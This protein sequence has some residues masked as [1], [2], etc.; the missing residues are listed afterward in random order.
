MHE[1]LIV[2]TD[3]V[4]T[5]IILGEHDT[6][7]VLGVTTERSGLGLDAGISEEV[8]E[9]VIVTGSE[10]LTVA[11]ASNGVDVSTISAA[12]VDSLGL[13]LELAC[14]GSPDG[15]DSVGTA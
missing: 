9:T 5:G 11:G 3:R 13:P 14:L 10:E 2:S 15:V 4:K 8:D 1:S 7:D 6:D 12:G